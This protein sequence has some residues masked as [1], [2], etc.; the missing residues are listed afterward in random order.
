MMAVISESTNLD[1]LT[2]S[3][4]HDYVEG[5]PASTIFHHRAWIELLIEQYRFP[6]HILA[7]KEAGQVVAAAPWLET[8]KPWGARKLVCLPF[9]DCMRV[10]AD[11]DR[12]LARFHEGLRGEPFGDYRSVV[13][14]TDRPL[15]D[16]P[17]P[18]N[19][20][21]HEIATDRP[22]DEIVAGYSSNVRQNTRKAQR[23]QLRFQRRTDPDAMQ[24]FYHLH[25]LTRRK[26]GV[27]IQ[28]RRF[29]AR[30]YDRLIRPGLGFVGVVSKDDRPLTASVF[31]VYNGAMI[32]KY[33]ASDARALPYR[34]NELMF[35]NAIRMATQEGCVRLDF[36][37]SSKRDEG[38]CRFKRKWG[39][40]ESG[41]Y[42]EHFL[43]QPGVSTSPG[44]SLPHRLGTLF[45][46]RS[47]PI[48]CR[49]LGEVLYKYSQ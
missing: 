10:L 31:L 30:L 42:H 24:T 21:R 11:D 23:N 12:A 20:V 1:R 45:I 13:L 18:S 2:L 38:L 9:T 6:L 8:R 32:Y 3:E 44:D 26:H 33:G 7:V 29:F 37:R 16:D 28:P 27:P 19:W 47:P 5:H 43:G 14:R 15:G 46:R 35:S 49:M 40:V 17:R 41:V 4:W 36:G 25:L 34:P 48:V 22:L 39:T